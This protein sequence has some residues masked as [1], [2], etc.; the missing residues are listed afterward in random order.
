MNHLLTA[1]LIALAVA[2]SFSQDKT[3]LAACL[4]AALSSPELAREIAKAW[5]NEEALYLS[6]GSPQ[7]AS[8]QPL[9][10]RLF[11]ELSAEDLSGLDKEV[12]LLFSEKEPYYLD[13]GSVME[14][15]GVFRGDRLS[16]TLHA[17][18][19]RQEDRRRVLWASFVLERQEADWA[20]IKQYVEVK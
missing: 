11:Q 19:P 15:G 17:G 14:V 5:E 18:L 7:A 20:I 1:L 9:F 4:K 6:N 2:P 8:T 16:L 12:R 3:D 13:V 10:E